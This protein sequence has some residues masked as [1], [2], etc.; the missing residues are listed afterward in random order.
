MT[1]IGRFGAV[2]GAWGAVDLVMI[3]HLLPFL[4]YY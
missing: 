3:G 1:G 2:F 4:A